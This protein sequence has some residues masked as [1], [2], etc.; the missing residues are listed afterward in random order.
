[1][2][3]KILNETYVKTG[4][5][6]Y[7]TEIGDVQVDLGYGHIVT[8]KAHPGHNGGLSV[9][10]FVGRYVT[11]VKPWIAHVSGTGDKLYVHFGRDDRSGRFNKSRM[12]RWEP[13]IYFQLVNAKFWEVV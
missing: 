3:I 12:I 11:S 10:G 13:K 7:G 6:E 9:G 8:A 2:T 5:N 4:E 1:M